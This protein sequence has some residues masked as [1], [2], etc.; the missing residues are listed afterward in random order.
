MLN[1]IKLYL[2]NSDRVFGGVLNY[3]F[4]TAMFTVIWKARTSAYPC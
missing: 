3:I 4:V 1:K 2:I